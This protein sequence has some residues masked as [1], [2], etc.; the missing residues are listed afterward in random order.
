VAV[1]RSNAGAAARRGVSRWRSD[2]ACIAGAVLVCHAVASA[3]DLHESFVRWKARYEH[4]QLDELPFSAIVLALGLVWYALRRRAELQAEL[5]RREAAEAQAA[6]LLAHKRELAQQLIAVQEA[7]RRALA[8]ELH[9]ELGQR[10]SAVLVETANLRRCGGD[11]LAMLGAAARADVA[12]QGLH[13]LLRD[14]LGRLRPAQ[15]D[16]LGVV[17]ALQDLCESWEERSGVACVFHPDGIEAPLPDPLDITL[18][19]IVQE[20]L[21]NVMRH[22]RASQVRIRLRCR[23][24]MLTL[25]IQD[26]GIGMDPAACTRGLGLLGATERAAAAGGTLALHSAP[27]AGLRLTLRLPLPASA[28]APE[29][30]EQA[31]PARGWPEA[32]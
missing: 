9:D 19:R 15:L 12:A 25:V 27:G 10:C 26:D 18:Y 6:A 11:R 23:D 22:A 3:L 5:Q 32:A 29:A 17:G 13:L 7:E 14:L 30:A 20:S 16:A 28:S 21:T 24:G 4:W 8:R 1:E 31:Q 2:L